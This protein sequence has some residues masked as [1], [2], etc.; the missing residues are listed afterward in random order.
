[1][2]AFWIGLPYLV[3]LLLL[4]LVGLVGGS[5]AN[6]MIYRFA[7][8]QPRAISPWGPLPEGV[9]R[10]G[11]LDRLPVLGWLGLRRESVV[12]GRG[13][14]IRPLL[15]ELLLPVVILW[16]YGFETQSGGLLPEELRF[17]P[18]LTGYEATATS[19]FFAHVL[20]LILMVA[21]TFIDFD[22]R[23]IPDIITI[24][25]TWL[26]LVLATITTDIYMPTSL[27][28]GGVLRVIPTTFDSP[29]FTPDAWMSSQGLWTGLAIWSVWCFALADWRWSDALRRR[30][31]L[32]RAIRHFVDGLFHYGF[33]KVLAAMW[34][35]GIVGIVGIWNLNGS[36]WLG[37]FTALVGLAV[38]GGVIWAIRIVATWALNME[39][40][41]F[42][43]VTLMAMIGAMVGWQAALL[44]FFLSPFAA[45]LI[46]LIRYAITR[47][48]YTPFGP[49]LC[50]GT[51]LTVI[52]WDRL[53]SR[54]LADNLLLMGPMLLWFSLAMLGLMAFML[55]VWRHL[56]MWLL[57]D[58]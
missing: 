51:A 1:M 29:W 20:L 28:M 17:P 23:T 39:A 26:A 55:F 58:R 44:A 41:G 38:G 56:K 14:W 13:F 45:I 33:W 18:F 15:I 2:V 3:R 34:L 48:A 30:R 47:D 36:A 16:L 31:G 46:V 37:L 27:V 21:A 9:S 11:W 42:G 10:R 52:G 49:Y 8:F 6:Y 7:Y 43:D 40:M 54:W 22:E 53:Y 32:A 19:I 25:G 57:R 50:A 24:P 35:L 12:H 5:L 4:V